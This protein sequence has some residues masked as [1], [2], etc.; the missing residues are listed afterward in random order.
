MIPFDFTAVD[1]AAARNRAIERAH[2][3]WI[4]VL[5]ADEVLEHDSAPKIE[6]LIA[7]GENA[8]YFLER[9]NHTSDSPKPVH[10]LCRPALSEPAPTIDTAA[11]STKSSMLRFCPEEGA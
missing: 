10:G 1:F 4:L 11:A 7:G 3:R 6:N 2:G 5:D 8:G 9:Q